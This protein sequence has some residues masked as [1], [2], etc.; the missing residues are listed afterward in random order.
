MGFYESD[1]DQ[2]IPYINLCVCYNQIGNKEE[3][4]KYHQLSKKIKP[5]SEIVKYNDEYFNAN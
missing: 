2:F 4:L 1:Y 5:K 3:A